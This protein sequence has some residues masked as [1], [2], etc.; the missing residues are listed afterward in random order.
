LDERIKELLKYGLTFIILIGV[1]VGG[2]YVLQGVL[3]T[4]YP[5]MV[6]VSQS[7]VPTLGVGNFIFVGEITNMSAVVAAPY[8]EGEIIVFRHP[9][10]PNEYIVH[11][12]VKMVEL[13]QEVAFYTRGDNNTYTIHYPYDG[14]GAVPAEDVLGRVVARAPIL[15]YF[16]LFIKTMLGFGLVL[17]FMGL[18]FFIDY[19]LP[20][21]NAGGQGRFRP[22]TLAP[23]L[24]APAV[25][26]SLWFVTDEGFIVLLE[27]AALVAWYVACFLIPL[28][29]WDDDI[30]VMLWLYYIVLVMVPISC[31]LVWWTAGITP[32]Q[33]WYLTSS[34]TMP[35]NWLLM[36]TTPLFDEAF[37]LI[38]R[39]LLPGCIILVFTLYGKRRGWEPFRSANRWLR[40][41]PM[42]EEP[43]VEGKVITDPGTLSP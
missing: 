21:R 32:S 6:V 23:L 3:G 5:M 2:N 4:E 8:P 31:D 18:A 38:L 29:F 42:A 34:S 17:A 37:A 7:M 33:W 40:G 30:S 36:R 43:P 9:Q 15:G 19:V 13:N 11:R 28:A 22:L 12:A 24:V 20:P 41:V 16:S 39:Y 26:A 25:I 35:V 10:N 1:F 14:W 27:S